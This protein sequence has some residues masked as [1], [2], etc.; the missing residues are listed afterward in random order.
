MSQD[1]LDIHFRDI[2]KYVR[3]AAVTTMNHL[4]LFAHT[5]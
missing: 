1:Q 2:T 4:M 3:V 5:A